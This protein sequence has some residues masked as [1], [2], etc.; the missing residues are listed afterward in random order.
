MPATVEAAAAYVALLAKAALKP[1][2]ITRRRAAITG[3]AP[4]TV[5]ILDPSNKPDLP[6]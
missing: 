6:S 5:A 1:S 4:V 2:T 3:H